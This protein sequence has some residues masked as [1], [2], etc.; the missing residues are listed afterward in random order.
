M[1]MVAECRVEEQKELAVRKIRV[2]PGP[3]SLSY[4]LY[5]L[6]QPTLTL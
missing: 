4:E 6:R 1:A 5:E 2:L 3:D